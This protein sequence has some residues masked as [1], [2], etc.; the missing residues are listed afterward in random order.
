MNGWLFIG[1]RVKYG[2]HEGVVMGFDFRIWTPNEV[3][4]EFED[5]SRGVLFAAGLRKIAEAA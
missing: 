1:D 5:G 2:V 4:V 3:V